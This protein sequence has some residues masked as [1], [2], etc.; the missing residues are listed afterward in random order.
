MGLSRAFTT[1][2]SICWLIISKFDRNPATCKFA[3]RNATWHDEWGLRP[4]FLARRRRGEGE[5]VI[6]RPPPAAHKLRSRIRSIQAHSSRHRQ[7]GLNRQS[8]RCF[9]TRHCSNS[10][11]N[12]EPTHARNLI[13]V[14]QCRILSKKIESNTFCCRQRQQCLTER[15]STGLLLLRD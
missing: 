2:R 11:I 12:Y 1:C 4:A 6:D 5:A 9:E 13:C 3:N 8:Q 10:K 15:V 14:A 7:T